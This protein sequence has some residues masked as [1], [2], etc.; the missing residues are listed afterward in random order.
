MCMISCAGQNREKSIC[1]SLPHRTV[2]LSRCLHALFITT[3]THTFLLLLVCKTEG[4]KAKLQ[5]SA[6]SK[7]LRGLVPP[8]SSVPRVSLLCRALHPHRPWV[9]VYVLISWC[10]CSGIHANSRGPTSDIL[11]RARNLCCEELQQRG[12]HETFGKSAWFIFT[13]R[14]NAKQHRGFRHTMFHSCK[15]FIYFP[16]GIRIFSA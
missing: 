6:L 14:A 1:E 8:A 10:K 2:P 13:I 12:T 11:D 3:L 7:R 5:P 4:A 16:R 15:L 9:K